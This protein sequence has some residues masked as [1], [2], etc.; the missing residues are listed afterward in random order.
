MTDF[1]ISGHCTICNAAVFDIAAVNEPHERRP[2]EPKRV[3]APHDNAVR[4]TFILF[5][6]SMADMT[7]CD[8]CAT[9]LSPDSY[10]E[11]WRKV[12]RSWQREIDESGK[13]ETHATWFTPQFFNGLLYEQTRIHWKEIAHG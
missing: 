8:D 13:P 12:L 3:G 4:I 2:G 9:A 5:D 1:K 7:F 6:G 10:T 11:I